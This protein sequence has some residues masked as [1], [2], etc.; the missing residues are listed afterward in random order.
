MNPEHPVNAVVSRRIDA[1]PDRVF[2]AW[3]S[4]EM[5]GR[6]MF[7]PALRDEEVV[8]ISLDA[9]VGGA[10]SFVVRRQ[11]AEIDHVGEYLEM[12]RPQRL[13][14]TW[15][16]MPSADRSRVTVELVPQEAGTTLTLTHE[17]HPDWAE[18]AART[19]A[20]WA[21]MIDALAAALGKA[22]HR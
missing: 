2:D 19:E 1:S 10:F 12:S 16:V 4:P 22:A 6:W 20:S 17:L 14:F 15:G 9:R 13:V 11:G 7:G 8:R 3:L 21:L 5:I 18:Y